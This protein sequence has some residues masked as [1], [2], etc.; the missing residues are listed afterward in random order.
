MP[1]GNKLYRLALRMLVEPADA[2]DAI[3]EV[4]IKLWRQRAS[5]AKVQNLEA[6]TM[7][8]TRNHCLDFLRA[9]Q[10][11]HP[12]LQVPATSAHRSAQEELEAK[13]GLQ[14]LQRLVQ[15]LPLKQQMVLQ[16]RDVEGLKYQEISELLDLSEGQVKTNLFRARQ[17]MKKLLSS[18]IL[19][20]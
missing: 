19:E 16:L 4:F 10:R 2:E 12:D 15:Q 14:R 5:L 9:R 20:K 18:E 13:E 1:L 3:Q 7:R 6:W 8:V 17:K 11:Q